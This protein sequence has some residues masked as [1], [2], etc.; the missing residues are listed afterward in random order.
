MS[1]KH[2]RNT[3]LAKPTPEGRSTGR[4]RLGKRSSQEHVQ[5]ALGGG[6]A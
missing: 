6:A 2:E 5:C 3:T 4:L 1:M